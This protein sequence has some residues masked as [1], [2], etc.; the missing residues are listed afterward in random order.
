MGIKSAGE[1]D[2]GKI[3]GSLKT[4]ESGQEFKDLVRKGWG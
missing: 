2:W 1:A 4:K 3:F